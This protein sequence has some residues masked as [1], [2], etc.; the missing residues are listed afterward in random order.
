MRRIALVCSVLV[1]LTLACTKD[2]MPILIELD[3]Q[4]RNHVAAS[5]PDGTLD[6]YI[7]PDEDDLDKIPADPKN[8][9]TTAK[10]E[11]GKFM[12]YDTGLAQDAVKPSGIGTYSCATC[13]IPEAGFKPGSFQGIA[14]GGTGFGI[15]G[16]N[17]VRNV[18]YDESE[19]DVQDARA[20]SLVNV[21]YV[22][23]TFW[24]G[25]F[26]ATGVNQGTEDVW[27]LDHATERNHLGF[28]GIETQNFE[29]LEIHRITINK[30]LL[31]EY[32]YTEMFDEAFPDI[33]E[34]ERYTIETASFAFSA[35]IRTIISNKAPFQYWLKGDED[36]MDYSS[37]KGAILFFGKANCS[38]CHY[39]ENLG[40]PE[41]HALGVNDMYQQPSYSTE[42]D[43]FRNLGRGGF[44]LK[45]EDL[46]KFKVP[47][48]YN[49]ADSDFF[50]HGASVKKIE[51]LVEYFDKA[52][53]E[54]PNVPES[55]ISLKFKALNLTAEEKAH[56]VQF[57]KVGLH[58]PNLERYKPPYIPSGFCSPN[59]DPQSI[60][61]LGC[62]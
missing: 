42:E 41:F 57:L 10:V 12:F 24:N 49:N 28:Q 8:P 17:R 22:T 60:I 54:N 61:D 2:K 53:P 43:D 32:G 5:S 40:S 3:N 20:L 45:D 59:A 25:M 21:A 33:P 7:L 62:D 29:G 44:T 1:F 56:L 50:F 55:Q 23:N 58:D 35:Y 46:Y 9:L 38:T 16:E 11:L 30:D 51:D 6:F 37:K 47:G 4:L 14:D 31:D 48:I 39:N 13:H 19:L 27:D 18:E 34:E 26:G 52:I 15:N 36:A